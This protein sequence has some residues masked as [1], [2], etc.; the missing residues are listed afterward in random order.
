MSRGIVAIAFASMLARSIEAEPVDDPPATE[1]ARVAW[2]DGSA[3][4]EFVMDEQTR[5]ISP[6]TAAIDDK[7]GGDGRAR[8]VLVAPKRGAAGNPWSWRPP[9]PR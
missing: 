9:H 7:A 1:C 6:S 8:C 3:R 5:A 4:Y 2:R